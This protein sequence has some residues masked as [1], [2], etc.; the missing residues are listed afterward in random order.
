MKNELEIK[1]D[2]YLLL[3]G[4]D[5]A[6]NIS[7]KLSKTLRPDSSDNEDIVISVLTDPSPAQI[8]E[9]FL[10]VNVY[11]P[12]VKHSNQYEEDTIRLNELCKLSL[13]ALKNAFGNGYRLSLSSQK[14]YEVPGKNEHFINNK[15]LYQ[16]CN[17]I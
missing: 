9:V 8:E 15:V 7:G 12:D 3:K 11:V 4:S 16:I 14:I 6:K 17:E 13:N 10:N 5:L 1:T 2:V